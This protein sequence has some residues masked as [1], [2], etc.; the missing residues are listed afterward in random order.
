MAFHRGDKQRVNE[1]FM[2]AFLSEFKINQMYKSSWFNST[3]YQET[4]IEV[5]TPSLRAGRFYINLAKVSR[6]GY[7]ISNNESRLC[8][9]KNYQ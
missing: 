1:I 6:K 2:L 9:K 7:I 4:M 3:S 5:P 8:H